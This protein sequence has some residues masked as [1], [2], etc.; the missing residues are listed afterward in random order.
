VAVQDIG[1]TGLGELSVDIAAGTYRVGDRFAVELNAAGAVLQKDSAT[2]GAYVQ[3]NEVPSTDAG[4]TI[5]GRYS[6]AL[7]VADSTGIPPYTAWSMRVI[8]AGISPTGV[9][10][11]GAKASADSSAPQP[12][13]VEFSYW[14][15]S[16]ASPT[17]QSVRVTLDEKYPP[18]TPVQIADGV[19]A[20]FDTGTLTITDPGEDA[21]FTVDGQPDQAGLLTALGIGGMFTGS[22]AA[23]LQVDQRLIDDPTQLNVGL[24]R[25]EGD[26]SNVLRL[27]AA[28]TEKLFTNGSFA[29]DDTYNAILSDVGVRIK[30][31]DRLSENQ[32]NIRSALENQRQ[33]VSGVNIDE[34]VGTLILQQQAYSAAA[35]VI[36]FA[37][38]NIQTLLDLAR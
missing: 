22:S 27:V 2:A 1:G 5:R 14:S 33:Q 19:Y 3:P 11:I 20:V 24:T 35:R 25:A 21:T 37:R 29:M 13:V 7:S 10:T 30:Q 16:E 38:E 6:G 34:E 18:G 28:R 32:T 31:S 23:T 9:G 4:F 26:N 17:L 8:S 12:P 15:G 36:T